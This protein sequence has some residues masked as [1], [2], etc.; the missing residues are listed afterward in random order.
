MFNLNVGA[1]GQHRYWQNLDV[2]KCVTKPAL[3]P[4]DVM[5]KAARDLTKALQGKSDWLGE[6]QKHDL[7]QLSTI[8]KEAAEKAKQDS[9]NPCEPE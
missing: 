3:T 1:K 5:S 7:Q 8:F 9:H 6:E 2:H 4:G